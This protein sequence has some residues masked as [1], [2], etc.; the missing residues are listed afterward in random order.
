M[1]V[2]ATESCSFG[3]EYVTH[4]VQYHDDIFIGLSNGELFK[5]NSS[6]GSSSQIQASGPSICGIAAT[7]DA[8]ITGN[9]GGYIHVW[10][11]RR[12][13]KLAIIIDARA[14]LT[15]LASSDYRVAAGSELVK[16][17]A[18]VMLWDIRKANELLWEYMDGH[19]DDITDVQ[20][21]PTARHSLLSGSTDGVINLYDTQIIDEDDAIY[22]TFNPGASIHRTGFLSEKRVFSLSHIE[23]LTIFQV[24][25][26][27][28][29]ATE[30]KPVEFGD[31]RAKW[32]CEYVADFVNDHFLIGSNTNETLKLVPF[33]DEQPRPPIHLQ[34]AH[35]KD[36]VRTFCWNSDNSAVYTGGEDGRVKH[37]PLNAKPAAGLPKPSRGPVRQKKKHL[38]K[39][40]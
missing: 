19:N 22:Q 39:P 11:P 3:N 18:K 15:C 1:Y 10:D 2:D 23:T 17:D 26:P 4:M 34:H 7:N 37:W 32:D 21:H 28:N 20:F 25:E 30:P 13:E 27:I 29:D 33:V 16:S 14:P 8:V 38:Y 31:L 24:A 9:S 6:L 36:V 12:R 35:G 5:A 40:Y